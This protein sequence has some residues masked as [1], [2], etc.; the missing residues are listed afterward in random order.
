[1]KLNRIT[2]RVCLEKLYKLIFDNDFQNNL[3]VPIIQTQRDAGSH[4]ILS[5]ISTLS[6]AQ[7]TSFDFT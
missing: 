6:V 4:F 7:G 3:S 1:M 5:K 2:V